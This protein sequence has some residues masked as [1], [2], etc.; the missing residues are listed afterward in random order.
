MRILIVDD[1]RDILDLVQRVLLAE[2]HEVIT[3][4]NGVEALQ[5]EA[6]YTPD[7]IVLDINLPFLDGWEVCRQIKARRSVPVIILSVRAEAS[8]WN[9]VAPL[10]PT[11]MSSNRLTSMIW[12]TGLPA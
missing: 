6:E 8:I 10:A 11:I 3:A 1:N 5:R 9:A 12:S 7:L 2:G 4:R